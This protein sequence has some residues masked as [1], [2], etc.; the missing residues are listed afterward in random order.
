MSGSISLLNASISS[1]TDFFPVFFLSS[2]RLCCSG[3]DWWQTASVNSLAGGF[4]GNTAILQHSKYSFFLSI[5][6]F[7]LHGN[8]KGQDPL[9]PEL[10]L[11]WLLVD[12]WSQT[13]LS[14]LFP[15]EII[16]ITLLF[17]LRLPCI[18]YIFIGVN[19]LL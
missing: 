15:N 10:K 9:K 19:M 5:Y 3:T 13:L 16:S 14:L 17:L 4:T 2:R 18:K 1:S 8:L 7:L 12:M 6:F 11:H